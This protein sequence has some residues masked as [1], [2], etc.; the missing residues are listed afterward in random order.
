MKKEKK[1]TSSEMYLDS[2]IKNTTL[3]NPELGKVLKKWRGLILNTARR[4]SFFKD[5][6][7]SDSLGDLLIPLVQLNET[8]DDLNYRYKKKVYEV[9]YEDSGCIVLSTPQFSKLKKTRFV[10]M[11]DNVEKVK[12]ANLSSLAYHKIQQTGSILLRNHFTQKN[13]YITISQSEELT[14][15]RKNE[16][17]K[18]FKVIKKKKLSKPEEVRLDAPINE[19]TK[20]NMYAVVASAHDQEATADFSL[21]LLS[22]Y[23]ECS[24]PARDV[25]S[26][27][28]KDPFMTQKEL[29]KATKLSI[30]H[31]KFSKREIRLLIDK[32]LDKRYKSVYAPYLIYEGNYFLRGTEKDNLIGLKDVENNMVFVEKE[33]VMFDYETPYRTPVHLKADMVCA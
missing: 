12:K 27:L 29:N 24:E 26:C 17:G 18:T 21:M 7:T 1:P 31:I 2:V 9:E 15:H 30:R 8:Y 14:K 13:G 25:L 28:L 6:S 32:V 4:V 33:K 5:E 22:I 11:R 19:S 20:D 3:N 16:Y 10:T 23:D